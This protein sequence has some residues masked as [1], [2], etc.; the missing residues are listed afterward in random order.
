MSA[1]ATCSFPFVEEWK[2]LGDKNIFFGFIDSV[3]SGFAQIAF[4]D[5]PFTGI[6]VIAGCFLGSNIQAVSGIWS[7]CLATLIAYLIGAPKSSIR[8][9]LYTMNA[10]LA[11][12]AIPVLVYSNNWVLPE[13]FIYSS[14]GAV[15][16]VMLTGALASL[17]LKWDIPVLAFPYS[18]TLLILLPASIYLTSM[19]PEPDI[20]PHI[21]GIGKAASSSWPVVDVLAAMF[22]G[23]AGV[24]WQ[25]NVASG[26]VYLLAV[27]VSSRVDG[28]TALVSVGVATL[29]AI[30]MGIGKGGI[31]LGVYGYNAVLIGQAIFGRTFR[32][33]VGSFAMYIVLSAIS[34]V[35]CASF[36]V[37]F[38]PLGAPVAAFPYVIIV[39]LTMLG[40]GAYTRLTPIS[41]LKWGVPETIEKELRNKESV[42]GE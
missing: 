24:I 21:M 35:L 39:I 23:L 9:G 17:L 10:A 34:V 14:I 42:A 32:M 19:N 6:L 38:A 11:G 1:Q 22:S 15:F 41:F 3:L 31:M 5:N 27:L 37:A 25:S 16:C 36:T 29:A 12:L 26:V 4:S 20:V 2:R 8:F 33:S 7:A 13:L 40:R 30:G 28:V 18:L